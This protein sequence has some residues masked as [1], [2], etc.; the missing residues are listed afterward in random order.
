MRSE[1]QQKNGER[2]AI[3]SRPLLRQCV[4]ARLGPFFIVSRPELLIITPHRLFPSRRSVKTVL[5]G[6]LPNDII[7]E[8]FERR[9]NVTQRLA[10]EMI[11]DGRQV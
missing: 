11:F 7:G 10:V 8:C 5:G 2:E 1:L 4:I 6:R 3:V 9:L